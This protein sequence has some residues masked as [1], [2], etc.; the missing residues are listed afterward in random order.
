MMLIEAAFY[1]NLWQPIPLMSWQSLSFAALHGVLSGL[2][3]CAATTVITLNLNS[4]TKKL[5]PLPES[6]RSLPPLKPLMYTALTYMP[7]YLL[8]GLLLAIP[9][10][11]EAFDKAYSEMTV[12]AWMPLFQI[13]RGVFWAVIIWVIITSLPEEKSRSTAAFALAIFGS[14]QLLHPNPYML[15]QLRAAHIIEVSTSM[16]IFGWIASGYFTS[17]LTPAVSPDKKH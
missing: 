15:E 8:A 11:G 9:L 16:G 3:I 10:G 7:V 14:V 13:G 5:E 6:N 17:P 4:K 12:P 1:L 2:G